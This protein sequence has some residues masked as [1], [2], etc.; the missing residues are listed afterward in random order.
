MYMWNKKA[1]S[2]PRKPLATKCNSTCVKRDYRRNSFIIN[3]PIDY[4]L[5]LHDH[6]V[7]KMVANSKC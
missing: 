4:C 7:Y 5:T 3:L 2:Q 1:H 6:R